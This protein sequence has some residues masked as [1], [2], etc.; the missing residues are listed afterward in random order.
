[1]VGRLVDWFGARA[2]TIASFLLVA[3]ATVPF[4]HAGPGT[5]LWWLVAVLLVRGLGIGAVLIPPMS[6]AYQ[7]IQ[8]AGIPHATM[9]TRIAQQVGASF[10]TAIVAVALQ[11][12]LGHGATGAFHGA[13]WWAIGI[14][15]AAV[16]PAIALPAKKPARSQSAG[17]DR[18]EGA[19]ARSV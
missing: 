7:D 1:V 9:N 17:L 5:S 19:S 8:P 18:P 6:V 16:I 4:A 3:V 12:L 10:G 13:F 14:S 15:V 11:S 2:V